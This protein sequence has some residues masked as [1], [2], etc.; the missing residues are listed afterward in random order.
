MARLSPAYDRVKQL[1]ST[2]KCAA[3]IAMLRTKPPASDA[4]AFEAVV[5]LFVCGDIDSALNVC[6]THTWNEEWAKLMTRALSELIADGDMSQALALSRKALTLPGFPLDASAIHLL[7]LQEAR[8]ID[9]ADAYMNTRLQDPPHDETFLLTMMAEMAVAAK[10]WRQ[11]Y[12][13]A[14][15]V[16]AS[17]PDDYR[18]LLAL[19]IANFESG[20][21]H[22]ALGNAYRANAMNRGSTAAILQ[23][24]RCDNKLGDYYGALAAFEQL[25]TKG[26]IPGEM[27]LELGTAYAGLD[28]SER[29]VGEYH[30]ALE[31]GAP[32]IAALRALAAIYVGNG[33]TASLEALLA[34]YREFMQ[35]DVD[36]MYWVGLAALSKSR[37]EEALSIFRE[38]R[39]LAQNAGEAYR[40]L[41]WP[42]PEPRVRHD[43]E[44]LELLARRGKLDGAGTNAL[45]VLRKYHDPAADL[46]ATFAPAGA[47]GEALK[48]ALCT[49]HHFPDAP[50]TGPALGEN[51]YPAIQRDYARDRLVVIDNFLSP[52]ALASLRSFCEEATIWKIDNPRG[53]VGAVLAQGF[54]PHVLLELSDALRRAMPGVL[55]D[56]PLMQAWGFKYDQRMQGINMHADFANVNVNFWITPDE[57][58]ADPDSGGL[59]VY[60]VPVPKSWTFAEYNTESEKLAAYLRVHKAKPQRIAYRANRCVL[61]DSSLIH[62]SDEMHFKPGYENRRVNL[63]LLY[64]KARSVE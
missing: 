49:T 24:M 48:R 4:D 2:G 46:N 31:P 5:C 20:N 58:C 53:Y 52:A 45:K 23:I 11:A 27:H 47:E 40:D 18:A 28:D 29:A 37:V 55:A 25:K 8:L 56:Q 33:N 35:A 36:C 26:A 21:V 63:T 62:I 19:S 32:S 14:S 41:P 61:F 42:V 10:R 15:A 16:L 9:E 59:V 13:A 30:A 51:D 57:A 22:E 6:R 60:D 50:F 39:V 38:T 34:S 3:A 44:Q 54:S 17:D 64:G 7:L 12:R 1:R 43:Y